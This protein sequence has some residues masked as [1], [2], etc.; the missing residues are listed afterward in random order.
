MNHTLNESERQLQ[1]LKQSGLRF[2][3]RLKVKA[4]CFVLNQHCTKLLWVFSIRSF[5]GYTDKTI[6]MSLLGQ[7]LSILTGYVEV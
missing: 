3:I 2:D 1:A 6:N 4:I 7:G 5:I